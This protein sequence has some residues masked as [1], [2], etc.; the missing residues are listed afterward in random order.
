[1]N[2]YA[3]SIAAIRPDAPE[4]IPVLDLAPLLRGEAGALG[5]LGAELRDAFENVGFYFVVN[6]GIP[7]SLIDAA[8][9][10]AR[11]F[12]A[13]ELDRKLALQMNKD[14]V[15]YL[16]FKSSTTRHSTLN[17]NNR[18]NLVE[19]YFTRRELPPEHPDR[20]SG[21]PFRGPNQWPDDLAGF[22]D[23]VLSYQT[24]MQDLG[25]RLLPLYAVALGLEADY[26]AQA[27]REPMFTLRMAHYPRQDVVEDNE[28]GLA[29][30]TDTSF[31]TM[32]AQNDVPGL[33]IRLPNGRW[34]DAPSLPG[35]ILVNGGD[36]LRRWT[37]ERFLATPHRVINRSGQERYAI[38]F[39]MDCDYDW[40]MGCLPTCQDAGNPPLYEPITYPE[41]MTWF[42]NL[43]YA[44]AV[45]AD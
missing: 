20:V 2:V 39:F 13:M 29:P 23:T 30:H 17:A 7:Q 25:L 33:S 44:R 34:L 31:M 5:S 22:R 45:K 42:R 8:F 38:P 14:N 12:H 4:T 35:S 26:F 27:F 28:F 18:P 3:P 21:L 19:A 32:L 15:G 16:P 43:N 37:N 24:A 6:H 1:M 9:D 40:Q 10:A 11:R 41:Y 36:L